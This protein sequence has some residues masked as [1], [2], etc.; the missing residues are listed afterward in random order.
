MT[1]KIWYIYHN[2]KQQGPMSQ[3]AICQLLQDE[4]I[5]ENTLVFKTGWKEWKSYK[6]CS[7]EILPNKTPKTQDGYTALAF[8]SHDEESAILEP[9][10]QE[11]TAR[12]SVNGQVIVHNNDNMIFAQSANISADGL[13]V[14]TDKPIFNIGEILKLTCRIQAIGIPFNAEAQ[15]VRR[16]SGP[17][18]DA[19]YGL[20]FTSIKPE[21]SNRIRQVTQTFKAAN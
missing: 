16:A 14:K 2:S 6:D 17:E 9:L 1:Q 13:F 7:H 4:K 3:K 18:E 20:F 12:A 19:G 8:S 10:Q 5:Q 15:V 21:I 11:R